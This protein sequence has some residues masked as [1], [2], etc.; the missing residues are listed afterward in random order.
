M[1][2]GR[3]STSGGH[4]R[5]VSRSYSGRPSN[6]SPQQARNRR[7]SQIERALHHPVNRDN[8]PRGGLLNGV[9]PNP[10]ASGH[11]VVASAT[12][13]TG[14]VTDRHQS[15]GQLANGSLSTV[16]DEPTQLIQNDNMRVGES[17]ETMPTSITNVSDLVDPPNHTAALSAP[18]DRNAAIDFAALGSWINDPP[19]ED[20]ILSR[21]ARFE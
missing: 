6:T 5:G 12:S 19:Y 3:S 7:Q 1:S 16:P 4:R 21:I 17:A 20:Q 2:G 10:R 13:L 18:N 8:V 15:N 11:V 9:I 14:S